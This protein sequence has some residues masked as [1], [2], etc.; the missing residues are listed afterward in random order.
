MPRPNP[1]R[2]AAKRRKAP[3]DLP[4]LIALLVSE[5][6][7]L[8]AIIRE[9]EGRLAP[10]KAQLAEATVRAGG[11]A[12]TPT[13]VVSMVM[14]ERKTVK[15]E[16]LLERGVTPAVIAYATDITPVSYAKVTA[17]KEAA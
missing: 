13:H 5:Y 15:V 7:Q 12:E 2:A 11:R 16:R 6:V 10:I 14:Q 4:N 17:K 1:R 3:E 8:S 9:A